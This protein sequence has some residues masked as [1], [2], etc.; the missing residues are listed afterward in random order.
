[1][2]KNSWYGYV[3]ADVLAGVFPGARGPA[4][5]TRPAVQGAQACVGDVPELRG[6]AFR[7][8]PVP[9][10]AAWT[11]DTLPGELPRVSFLVRPVQGDL[12]IAPS[13]QDTPPGARPGVSLLAGR[14]GELSN[15]WPTHASRESFRMRKTTTVAPKR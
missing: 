9:M 2:S 6:P 15:L 1:M 3:L 11:Q 10:P 5:T 7:N 4:N 13:T 14:S 8:L 12:L